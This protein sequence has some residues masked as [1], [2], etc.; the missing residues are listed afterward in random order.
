MPGPIDT[1]NDS[2]SSSKSAGE[3]YFSAAPSSRSRPGTVRLDLGDLHLEL[4]T[5]RGVFSAD[6]VD[7]GTRELLR[8]LPS[9]EDLPDGDIVDVGCGYGP[10]AIAL[11]TRFPHR[12]IVAVDINQRARELCAENA[13]IAGV[14]VTVVS[15]EQLPS[16]LRVA[17]VVTNPPIRV[18][19]EV[20]HDLLREWMG[21]LPP[22]GEAWLVIHKHLGGDSVADWLTGE[23]YG[24]SKERS[25]KGYRMLRVRSA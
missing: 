8:S 16:D 24:V 9:F 4:R 11:A 10:I 5:D 18:G 21:R 22:E 12:R 19:K 3:Q 15:P 1:P 25:R 13:R 23:G 2:E 6:R 20:L 17:A 14:S 7:L